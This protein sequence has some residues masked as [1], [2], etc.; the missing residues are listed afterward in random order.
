[1]QPQ[2]VLIRLITCRQQLSFTHITLFSL[3]HTTLSNTHTVH[4][5]LPSPL[6]SQKCEC[7]SQNSFFLELFIILFCYNIHIWLKITV[8][9][10]FFVF[11]TTISFK[12]TFSGML[13]CTDNISNKIKDKKP[14][15]I[16]QLTH[17]EGFGLSYEVRKWSVFQPLNGKCEHI[18][19]TIIQNPRC[20]CLWPSPWSHG[21]ISTTSSETN[22][23]K[24]DRGR[25]EMTKNQGEEGN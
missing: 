5:R 13:L 16:M 15:I 10:S 14:S 2:W 7:R 12:S 4:N 23:H 19:H 25:W 1:M 11:L 22:K 24:S 3:A 6:N 21:H 20:C 9:A 18:R 8:F 17:W